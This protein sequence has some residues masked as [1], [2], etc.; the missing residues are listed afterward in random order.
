MIEFIKD[1]I[2]HGLALRVL[3]FHASSKQ[4]FHLPNQTQENLS[5]A[6]YTT[7]TTNNHAQQTL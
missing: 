1:M 5:D 2:T 3:R 6:V 4:L 7:T